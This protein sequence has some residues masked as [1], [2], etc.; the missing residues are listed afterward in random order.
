[1]L[2]GA[3]WNSQ[4]A[5]KQTEILAQVLKKHL[6]VADNAKTLAELAVKTSM[7]LSVKYNA[8]S[9]AWIHNTMVHFGLRNRGLCCHWT[10]DLLSV[11]MARKL[12]GFKVYWAVSK[13]G[14][15]FEHSSVVVTAEGEDFNAGIVLDPWRD[16]GKLY[17]GSVKNDKYMWQPHP[18]FDGTDTITCQ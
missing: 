13:Y 1:M 10:M 7:D 17:W 6:G 3:R 12:P 5:K 9:P 15:Y 4:D 14:D 8:G 2:H 11:L 18:E 16:S